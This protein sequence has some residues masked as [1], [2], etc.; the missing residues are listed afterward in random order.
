MTGA[1]LLLMVWTGTASG[2]GGVAA[3][4]VVPFQSEAICRIVGTQYEERWRRSQR[5]WRAAHL[6]EWR[7]VHNGG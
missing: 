1:W 6:Q 5:E 7:C 4:T 2:T 3:P